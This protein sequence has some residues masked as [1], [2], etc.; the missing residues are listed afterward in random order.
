MTDRHLRSPD[1]P[2]FNAPTIRQ[3]TN[4]RVADLRRGRVP[5]IPSGERAPR[6]AGKGLKAEAL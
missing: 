5:P 1:Q 3:G 4:A 2:D 6:P